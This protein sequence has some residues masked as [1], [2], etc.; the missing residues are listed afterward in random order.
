M[1]E[2]S[3]QP[4]RLRE[5]A[6]GMRR[7]AGE[8]APLPGELRALSG[9]VA[10]VVPSSWTSLSAVPFTAGATAA[11][12]T[13]VEA[14]LAVAARLADAADRYERTDRA[15]ARA[16]SGQSPPPCVPVPE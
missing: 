14:L 4:D 7:L 10:T 2:V 12:S 1:R 6:V 3:A 16:A 9:Q 5:V 8:L 11:A 13:L 15:I